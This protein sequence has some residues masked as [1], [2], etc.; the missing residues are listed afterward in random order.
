MPLTSLSGCP[1]I[2]CDK[3]SACTK[4]GYTDPAHCMALI[5]WIEDNIAGQGFRCPFCSKVLATERC[6]KMHVARMHLK[7]ETG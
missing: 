3:M 4:G 5:R 2:I 7:E 1:C 6:M